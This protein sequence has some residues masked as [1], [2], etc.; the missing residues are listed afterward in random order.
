MGPNI[1]ILQIPYEKL[2]LLWSFMFS[3][4]TASLV[5]VVSSADITFD[6][7]ESTTGIQPKKLQ[8][9][10]MRV[11]VLVHRSVVFQ[12]VMG[13]IQHSSKSSSHPA[14]L[15]CMV[16]CAYTT[17]MYESSNNFTCQS[18]SATLQSDVLYFVPLLI[19][20]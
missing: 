5:C 20:F 6:T 8:L 15:C 1:R 13:F 11:V 7:A 12:C 17:R 19:V 16:P 14:V 2:V 18:K 9:L 10:C 4:L 3:G